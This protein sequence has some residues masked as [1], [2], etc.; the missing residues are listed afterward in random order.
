MLIKR[1]SIYVSV[2]LRSLR[3]RHLEGWKIFLGSKWLI[4]GRVSQQKYVIDL[5]KETGKIAYKSASAPIDPNLKFEKAEED[6][7]VDKGMYQCF[8]GKLIYL[9]H[10]RL[11]LAY[12]ISVIS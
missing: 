7:V 1:D 9:S 3:S 4:L 12:A 2:R 11:D 10:T 6:I 8:V 5:L